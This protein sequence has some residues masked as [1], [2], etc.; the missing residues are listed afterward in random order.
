MSNAFKKLRTQ[1]RK[2]KAGNKFANAKKD[3][4]FN[5]NLEEASSPTKERVSK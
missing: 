1:D 3:D 4:G 2:L 5:F